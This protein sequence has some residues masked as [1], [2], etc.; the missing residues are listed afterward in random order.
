MWHGMHSCQALD[1]HAQAQ[2]N[3][4]VPDIEVPLDNFKSI[5][6]VGGYKPRQ[7]KK[8]I[9]AV[10]N[11]TESYSCLYTAASTSQGQINTVTKHALLQ[12]TPE[13][14]RFIDSIKPQKGTQFLELA[15]I[16]SER[17]TSD[18]E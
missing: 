4:R 15:G 17:I 16:F 14:R 1:M 6:T 3:L 18:D 10:S 9:H 2:G 7:R 11:R 13:T 12:P 5:Q 8:S